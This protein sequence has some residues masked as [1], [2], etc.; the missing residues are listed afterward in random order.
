MNGFRNYLISKG[1]A[2]EK[3]AAYYQMWVAKYLDFKKSSNENAVLKDDIDQFISGLSN[4][5]SDWQVEQANEA[6]KD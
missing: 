1:I 5:Y 3:N 6:V 2:T 4:N